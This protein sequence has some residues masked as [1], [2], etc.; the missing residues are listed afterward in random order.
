MKKLKLTRNIAI[1]KHNH[2]IRPLYQP[3]RDIQN[4]NIPF[5]DPSG[6][7]AVQILSSWE[8][9]RL[10]YQEEEEKE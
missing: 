1:F 5:G 6:L 7:N 10:V 3:I 9:L 4:K 2:E 8:R